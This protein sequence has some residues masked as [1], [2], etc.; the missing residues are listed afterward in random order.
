M[1]NI[2]INIERNKDVNFGITGDGIPDRGTASPLAG[3][4]GIFENSKEGSTPGPAC[5]GDVDGALGVKGRPEQ[6]SGSILEI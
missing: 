2:W 5:S 1:I 3:V 4:S 6:I